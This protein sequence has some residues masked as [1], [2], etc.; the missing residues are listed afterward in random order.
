MARATRLWVSYSIAAEGLIR[1]SD[2]EQW[3]VTGRRRPA[4]MWHCRMCGLDILRGNLGVGITV[5]PP[6]PMCPRT[7]CPGAGWQDIIAM[8]P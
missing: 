2:H 8:D 7:G 6:L 4:T 3:R 1:D 5:S